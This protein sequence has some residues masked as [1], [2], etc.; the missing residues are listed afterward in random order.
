[1]TNPK[2]I[3]AGNGIYLETDVPFSVST[4]RV[5]VADVMN[6]QKTDDDVVPIVRVNTVA[7]LPVE[8]VCRILLYK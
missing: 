7:E 4:E 2:A 3:V 1:M 8:C 6:S 5:A